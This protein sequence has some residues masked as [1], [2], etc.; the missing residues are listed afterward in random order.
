MEHSKHKYA[1]V[2]REES[3]IDGT[4]YTL[5]NLVGSKVDIGCFEGDGLGIIILVR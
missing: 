1:L 4:V 3:D 5:E 2:C